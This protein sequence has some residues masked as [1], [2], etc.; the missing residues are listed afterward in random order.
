VQAQKEFVS[1]LYTSLI[2]A[3]QDVA[4]NSLVVGVA[5]GDA[6]AYI[7]L[8]FLP[9]Q[10][11]WE[12][13]RADALDLIQEKYQD[14]IPSEVTH[15]LM[16]SDEKNIKLLAD[17]NVEIDGQ[18]IG[19]VLLKDLSGQFSLDLTDGQLVQEAKD[20][21]GMIQK[22][23]PYHD[24]KG[25]F[26][27]KEK[28]V[29]TLEHDKE[30]WPQHIKDLKLP[31]AWTQV[32]V[33]H[34]PEADL[35][36]I[37]KDVKGRDQ[38]VY[39]ERFK[40][41]QSAAKFDRISS[42]QKDMPQIDKKLSDLRKNGTPLQKEHGDVTYLIRQTGLRPGSDEDTSAKVKA[43]G[44]TTLQGRHVVVDKSG[45][46][47]LSFVGKKG[48]ELNLPIA[49]RGVADMLKER[50]KES[51]DSEPLFPKVTDA[52]L[53]D[54]I[55][56]DMG[57]KEYKTKD[58]RTYLGT[59]T[60]LNLVEKM[61]APKDKKSYVKAV[62]EVATHVSKILGNTPTIALQSYIAPQVFAKWR[63]E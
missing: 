60:A 62:K 57:Q 15:I 38:Y 23:D 18:Q 63:I 40:N 17:L 11:Q 61:Q 12:T 36:A 50:K 33:S 45:R 24:E 32:R 2:E 16:S 34:D 41:S 49:D 54:F 5:A 9:T 44:A 35:L 6:A 20:H 28:A 30:K 59:T 21:L 22:S 25:K 53:R 58:F 29:L 10:D 8:G 46:V 52:S 3:G 39:S 19:D 14:Y 13:F 43:Y 37:G 48:V 26:T 55:H 47:T 42:L 51:A 1:R 27:S 4:A 31:P 56:D 7:R